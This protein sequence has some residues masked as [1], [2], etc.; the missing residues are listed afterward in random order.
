MSD[1]ILG[2]FHGIAIKDKRL[3]RFYLTEMIGKDLKLANLNGVFGM[4]THDLNLLP[5]IKQMAVRIDLDPNLLI[6]LIELVSTD[7]S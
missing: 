5:E 7:I 2:V 6:N 3:I 1:A 4:I